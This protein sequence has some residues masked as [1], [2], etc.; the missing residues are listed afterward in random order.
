[1]KKGKLIIY[2]GPSG[3][4]KGTVKEKFFDNKDLNLTFSISATSREKRAG[5]T[6]GIEYFFLSKKEFEEWIKEDKFI[7]W[8]EY[9][10]NY[11]GTPKQYV[12]EQLNNGK[13]VLLE[14]EIQGVEQVLKK[15]PDAIKI[16]LLP[17]SIEVLR[18]RL[19][20]RSTE[21]EEVLEK[22]ISRAKKEIEY[23]DLF[24]YIFINDDIEQVANEIKQIL[25]GELK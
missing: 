15:Y 4:G 16:F 17:P 11:Y 3:V 21:S 1:M 19:S 22:R 18:E 6:H 23:K 7:E 5:E 24:D 12:E 10:G 20:K 8:A 9:I 13:N 2:A 14:I 25:I